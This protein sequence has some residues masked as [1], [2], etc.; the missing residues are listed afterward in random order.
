MKAEAERQRAEEARVAEAKRK[1]EEDARRK[2]EEVRG[3]SRHRDD[4]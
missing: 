1:K 3:D 4:T 2:E